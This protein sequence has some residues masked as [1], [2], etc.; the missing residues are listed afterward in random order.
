MTKV[1]VCLAT[2]N[3][4]KFIKEQIISIL[5]QLN[6]DDELIIVDDNSNDDSVSIILGFNDKRIFLFRNI[7]NKGVNYSFEKAIS[8]ATGDFIVLS[9]QDDIWPKKRIDI[10]LESNSNSNYL[11]SGNS[12]YIDSYGKS[13]TY[14]ITGVNSIN[15][16]NNIENIFKILIGVTNY[17]GCTMGFKKELIQFI[18]P[19]PK[20]LESH[21]LHIAIIANII[22]KNEHLDEI[23]LF[24]RIHGNNASIINRSILSKIV[25]RLYI[26]NSVFI[27]LFRFFKVTY[28]HKH[29]T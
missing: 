15:S 7:K 18:L 2:Y 23:I 28:V 26:L 27:G 14:N 17:Y 22:N 8:L 9:D 16:N 20:F 12:K 25:A 1:S 24:R 10:F 19:F 5:C 29:K 4:S 11:Y 21:D 13:I 3:G 6:I